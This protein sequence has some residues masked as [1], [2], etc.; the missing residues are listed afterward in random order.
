MN[1]KYIGFFL[2]LFPTTVSVAVTA[3]N[4]EYT[5]YYSEHY[6]I[7]DLIHSICS[8]LLIATGLAILIKKSRATLIIVLAQVFIIYQVLGW[9]FNAQRYMSILVLN[10]HI[11]L[12]LERNSGGAFTTT[13]FT[14]LELSERYFLLFI[15]R[16]VIKQYDSIA[17]GHLQATDNHTVVIELQTYSGENVSEEISHQDILNK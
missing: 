11:H 5:W 7:Y 12:T 1:K 9:S 15:K 13:S 2:V 17:K 4:L 8:F 10:S 6:K 3:F 16:S 14:T